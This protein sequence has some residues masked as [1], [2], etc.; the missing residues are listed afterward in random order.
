M[1]RQVMAGLTAAKIL[2]PA[3]IVGGGIMYYMTMA[4]AKESAKGSNEGLTKEMT[5]AKTAAVSCR[6]GQE[7][8]AGPGGEVPGRNED[9]GGAEGAEG[10]SGEEGGGHR[11]VRPSRDNSCEESSYLVAYAWIYSQTR[12]I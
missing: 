7:L 3:L 10:V 8:M 12:N 4:G 1:V 11:P 9:R 6:S 5:A 2:I